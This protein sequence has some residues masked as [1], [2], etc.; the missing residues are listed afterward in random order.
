M[1]KHTR[2]YRIRRATKLSNKVAWLYATKL[3]CLQH[4]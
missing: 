3:P 4:E 2:Q 1:S